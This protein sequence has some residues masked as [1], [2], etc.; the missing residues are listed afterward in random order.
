MY[1]DTVS[2]TA[3]LVGQWSGTTGGASNYAWIPL[4]LSVPSYTA[5]SDNLR[6]TVSAAYSNGGSGSQQNIKL[7]AHHRDS[8]QTDNF[9]VYT[10]SNIGTLS[11][12]VTSPT[13]GSLNLTNV[14]ASGQDDITSVI[15][16]IQ[17]QFSANTNIQ[18][19]YITN[20]AI[21]TY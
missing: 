12:D 3:V 5:G 19:F 7:K 6:V 17:L 8:T 16:G 9:R 18:K 1:N 13:T 10:S 21:E 2:S 20:V 4:E 14:P 15:V 11:S